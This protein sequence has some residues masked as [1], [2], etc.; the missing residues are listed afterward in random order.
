MLILAMVFGSAI[1]SLFQERVAHG[2]AVAT[3]ND[4]LGR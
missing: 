4:G 3:P 2:L 1:I